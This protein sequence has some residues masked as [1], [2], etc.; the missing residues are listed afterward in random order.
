MSVKF[1]E[2][3]LYYEMWYCNI[4]VSK[5]WFIPLNDTENVEGNIN[6]KLPLISKRN[7]EV[8]A[9]KSCFCINIGHARKSL[10]FHVKLSRTIWR[11][12][13]T[14][15]KFYSWGF[16]TFIPSLLNTNCVGYLWDWS[17]YKSIDRLAAYG[18]FDDNP[19]LTLEWVIR[20]FRTTFD[21]FP[22]LKMNPY[23]PK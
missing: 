2:F 8:V 20:K 12:F 23:I 5:K 4:V 22:W 3:Q 9:M 11:I 19:L 10:S 21:A 17:S 6:L 7:F 14:C 16:G 18:V 1:M 15:L 13:L